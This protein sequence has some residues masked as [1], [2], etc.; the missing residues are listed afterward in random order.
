MGIVTDKGVLAL[1]GS[2]V[3][4]GHDRNSL[5]VAWIGSHPE[6]EPTQDMVVQHAADT[7]PL[8]E[9]YLSEFR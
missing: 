8:R 2:L 4:R 6:T 3:L 9:R 5:L 7:A 1:N